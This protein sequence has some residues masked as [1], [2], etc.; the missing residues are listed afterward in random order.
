METVKRF[1]EDV[2]QIA[3]DVVKEKEEAGEEID[4]EAIRTLVESE[5]AKR[6][7]Q[8]RYDWSTSTGFHAGGKGRGVVAV[9][10]RVCEEFP[11]PPETRRARRRCGSWSWRRILLPVNRR[12]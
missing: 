4:F 10:L 5:L 6:G 11:P 1:G 9:T 8:L 2:A 3:L 7:I 12:P